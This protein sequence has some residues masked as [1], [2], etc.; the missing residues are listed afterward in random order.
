[1]RVACVT[2]A[3]GRRDGSYVRTRPVAEP[4]QPAH[5]PSGLLCAHTVPHRTSVVAHPSNDAAYKAQQ[6]TSAAAAVDDDDH[7][8]G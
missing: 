2:D 5:P 3:G 4:T 7:A 6:T 8:R 1:M